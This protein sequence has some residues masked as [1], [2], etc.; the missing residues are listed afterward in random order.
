MAAGNWMPELVRLAGGRNLLGQ[1]GRHSPWME[2]RDLEAADPDK[3]LLLPCGIDLARTRAESAALRKHSGWPSLRAVRDGEVYVLDGNRF[4][5]RPG[6]RLE[7]SLE[8]LAEIF[9]PETFRFGHEN[10][11]WQRL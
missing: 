5:N 9:H 10:D 7:Q 8:I 4:F 3:I 2:F 1:A 11:A 6:P